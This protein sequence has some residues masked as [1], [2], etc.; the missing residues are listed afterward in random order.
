MR[1]YENVTKIISHNAKRS[2]DQELKSSFY[3]TLRQQKVVFDL[4]FQ[5]IFPYRFLKG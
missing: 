2:F 1:A 4:N 5:V 3:F